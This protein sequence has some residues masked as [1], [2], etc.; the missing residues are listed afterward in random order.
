MLRGGQSY[1]GFNRTLR[2]SVLETFLDF[3]TLFQTRPRDVVQVYDRIAP[4]YDRCGR[5][6]RFFSGDLHRSLRGCVRDMTPPGGV[7]LDAG[8]GTGITT[9]MVLSETRAGQVDLLDLSGEMI[10]V[11]RNKLNDPRVRFVR[12]DMNRLPYPDGTFDLVVSTWA[13][14]TL[15]DPKAAV[16][17]F[18]RVIKD[19]GA[20]VYA[21]SS[22]PEQGF[23]RFGALLAEWA[24]GE[25]FAFRFLPRRERP[26]HHCAMS[27][28][29]TFFGGLMTLVVLRKC[30]T[31]EDEAAPCVL[32]VSWGEGLSNDPGRR[33]PP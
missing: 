16:R 13:I 3:T 15:D 6:W 29:M 18:L 31:V 25:K 33:E 7:V 1:A 21:F 32:P 14:E 22:R 11:A 8:G 2:T 24:L 26:Y 17:E 5:L 27:R 4:E 10:R 30:C 9:A 28:L 19:D 23:E 20:V 12:G